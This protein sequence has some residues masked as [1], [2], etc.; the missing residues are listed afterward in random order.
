MTL[1]SK[2]GGLGVASTWLC[3]V[4]DNENNENTVNKETSEPENHLT[5]T[6]WV[7]FRGREYPLRDT[8]QRLPRQQRKARPSSTSK[9]LRTSALS[10]SSPPRPEMLPLRESFESLIRRGRGLIVM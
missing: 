9:L 8:S 4:L 3:C 6:L 2:K 10:T 7:S 1:P 5:G